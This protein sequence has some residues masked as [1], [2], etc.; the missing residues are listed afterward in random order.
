MVNPMTNG[1]ILFK[2]KNQIRAPSFQVLDLPKA[3]S[4]IF[5]M[6]FLHIAPRTDK[7][8]KTGSGPQG[9]ILWIK[10]PILR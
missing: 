4:G 5:A 2:L 1:M 7:V 6:A 9:A 3:K 10:S 8:I